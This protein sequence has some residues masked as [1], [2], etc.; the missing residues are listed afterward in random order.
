MN[1]SKY[2]EY[3][4]NNDI[5]KIWELKNEGLNINA[6]LDDKGLCPLLYALFLCNIDISQES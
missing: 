2:L 3:I 6:I 1:E 4:S 5:Q